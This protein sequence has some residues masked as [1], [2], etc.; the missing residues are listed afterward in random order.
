MVYIGRV[1]IA[2]RNPKGR[3]FSTYAISGRSTPSKKRRFEFYPDE[4]RINVAGIGEP[5]EEQRRMADLIFYNCMRTKGQTLIV[6]NGAQT[7]V[8][9]T[10]KLNF[11]DQSEKDMLE[12]SAAIMEDWKYEPDYKPPIFT[13]RTGLVLS[14]S[15]EA[16]FSIAARQSDEDEANVSAVTRTQL[17][18]PGHAIGLATYKGHDTQALPWRGTD[19]KGRGADLK[20]FVPCFFPDHVFS[21]ETPQELVDEMYGFMDPRYVVAAAAAIWDGE[22]WLLAEPNNRFKDEAEFKAYAEANK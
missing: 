8:S 6:T 5:T 1:E 11:Y 20:G 12:G 18:K 9:S 2:G 21:G 16:I 4:G 7:D 17:N 19:L 15:G 10:G 14:P 13:P 22:K 3:L